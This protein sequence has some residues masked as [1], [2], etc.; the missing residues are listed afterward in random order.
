MTLR[1]GVSMRAST[2]TRWKAMQIDRLL[3]RIEN[4]LTHRDL[5][6]VEQEVKNLPQSKLSI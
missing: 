3:F 1:Q 2:P 4:V 5:Q 6:E